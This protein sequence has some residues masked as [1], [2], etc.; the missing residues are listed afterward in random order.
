MRDDTD[1]TRQHQSRAMP[2]VRNRNK[3]TKGREVLKERRAIGGEGRRGLGASGE[4]MA[5]CS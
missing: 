1:M 4:P 3:A 5:M 2:I